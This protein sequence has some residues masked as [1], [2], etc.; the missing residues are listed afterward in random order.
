MLR[1]NQ[2]S[3]LMSVTENSIRGS[4]RRRRS[5][6]ETLEAGCGVQTIPVE[7]KRL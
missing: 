7:V 2:P 6:P 1:A 4:F 5:R 3:T